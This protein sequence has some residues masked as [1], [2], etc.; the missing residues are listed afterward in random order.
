[1]KLKDSKGLT[2]LGMIFY[3][4]VA[5]LILFGSV[6]Y[7]SSAAYARDRLNLKFEI[8]IQYR[9]LM[10]NNWI[11]HKEESFDGIGGLQTHLD[12]S[13]EYRMVIIVRKPFDLSGTFRVRMFSRVDGIALPSGTDSGTIIFGPHDDCSSNE[14]RCKPLTLN[15]VGQ[16]ELRMDLEKSQETA[17]GIFNFRPYDASPPITIRA[18]YFYDGK[19]IACGSTVKKG[20]WIFGKKL[21][22]SGSV[23][24]TISICAKKPKGSFDCA[25]DQESEVKTRANEK[26]VLRFSIWNNKAIEDKCVFYVGDKED[27]TIKKS[28]KRHKKDDLGVFDRGY[29]PDFG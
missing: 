7:I 18:R 15:D 9:Q 25:D 20:W 27:L 2:I 11:T 16:V 29:E 26:G 17:L 23:V 12:S 8:V 13:A 14:V 22:G 1:M 3:F 6:F 10:T 24:D 5:T 19:E 4:L 21:K 28:S